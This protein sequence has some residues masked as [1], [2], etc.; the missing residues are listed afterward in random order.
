MQSLHHRPFETSDVYACTWSRLQ[1]HGSGMTKT[2][3]LLL[4]LAA[5]ACKSSSNASSQQAASLPDL[6]KS[7]DAVRA[8]FNAHKGEARFVTLLSPT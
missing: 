8:D 5:T 7:L 1:V 6:T 3:L 4:A 2:A